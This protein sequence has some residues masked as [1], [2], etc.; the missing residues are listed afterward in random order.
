MGT[1]TGSAISSTYESLIFTDKTSS[2]VGDI[3]YTDGSSDVKMTTLTSALTFSG[4]ITATSGIKLSNNRIY[5]SDGGIA[6]SLD[7]SDNVTI[8]NYLKV[9]GNIIQASDGGNTITMDTDDNVTIGGDLTV[10]GNDIKSFGGTTAFTLSGANATLAGDLTVAGGDIIG[11]TDGDLNI[12]S[13][14]NMSFYLDK[15]FDETGQ[16][17][18]FYN[19]THTDVEIATLDESGNLQIDGDLTLGGNDIK[20][21][22]GTTAITTSG[23]NVT[24]AGALSVTENLTIADNKDIRFTSTNGMDINDGSTS[25]ISFAS[26][27]TTFNSGKTLTLAGTTTISGT[28]LFTGNVGN[29]PGTGITGGSGTVCRVYTERFGTMIKTTIY[30]DLTGL[31]ANGT[32]KIIGVDGTS[33]PCYLT[34]IT[35]GVNGTVV[36]GRMSCLEAPAGHA[37]IDDIDLAFSADADDVEA[38]SLTSGTT[39]VERAGA[40]AANDVKAFGTATQVITDNNYLYLLTGEAA[41]DTTYTGG[42]FLIE[43]WGTA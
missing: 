5:A 6:I 30:L 38:A 40:W 4:L 18:Y 28:A 20:A 37:S 10:A 19:G 26:G 42:K 2:G 25:Y 23:A 22:D 32:A 14:G 7:T 9:T 41:T 21:S 8:G 16:K 27:G 24:L 35:S 13:D 1:L 29:T 31:Q 15:D 12:K 39:L 34:R 11:T 36:S 3:Y 43:I 17:F 33:N